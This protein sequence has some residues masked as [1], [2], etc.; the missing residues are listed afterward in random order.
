V[1][2]SLIRLEP[3]SLQLTSLNLTDRL[4]YLHVNGWLHR[5]VKAANLLCDDDGTVLLS[6]FGVSSSLFQDGAL[7]PSAASHEME[8]GRKSFVGTPCYMAPEIVQR[9]AYNAKA[10]IWSFGITAI[11]LSAGRAPNSL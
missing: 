5:D 3:S 9:K 7:R 1:R 10:D 11:E 8:A 6:D 2:S 4:I